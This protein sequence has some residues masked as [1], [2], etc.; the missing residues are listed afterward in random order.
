[1]ASTMSTMR[2]RAQP[3]QRVATVFPTDLMDE[4]QVQI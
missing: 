1:M 3:I 2:S 4:D